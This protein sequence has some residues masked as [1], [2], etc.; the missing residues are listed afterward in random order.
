MNI[1][2]EG[3]KIEEKRNKRLMKGIGREGK[4]GM[5][6]VKVGKLRKKKVG[7]G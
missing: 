5:K 2:V 3:C 1:V 6:K 4:K 7:E